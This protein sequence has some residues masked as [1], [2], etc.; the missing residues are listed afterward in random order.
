MKRLTF[1]IDV[2]EVIAGMIAKHVG[3]GK[4]FALGLQD[5]VDPE[6]N[7]R[8]DAVISDIEVRHMTV[9]TQDAFGKYVTP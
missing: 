9:A 8:K 2:D 1:S 6:G 5:Y 3:E 4:L 7:R